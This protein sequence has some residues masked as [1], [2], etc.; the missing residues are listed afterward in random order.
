MCCDTWQVMEVD[1]VSGGAILVPENWA[2]EVI[3][4][5]KS[6]AIKFSVI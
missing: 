3:L 6:S 5:E 1:V 2:A 4:D